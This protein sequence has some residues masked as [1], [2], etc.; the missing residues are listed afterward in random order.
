MSARSCPRGSSCPGQPG[1]SRRP[2]AWPRWSDGRSAAAR[3]D[4]AQGT[5]DLFGRQRARLHLDSAHGKPIAR[6]VDEDLA[7]R[8]RCCRLQIPGAPQTWNVQP[9]QI[10]GRRSTYRSGRR[11]ARRSAAGAIAPRQDARRAPRRRQRR[12]QRR[13]SRARLRRYRPPAD[14]RLSGCRCRNAATLAAA[15]WSNGV[16]E[17]GR[18]MK[19]ALDNA[20]ATAG[21][22]CETTT[23]LLKR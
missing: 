4:L 16:S 10:A 20:L 2:T 12:W 21:S 7:P 14:R 5:H 11:R 13:D 17:R 9:L 3:R 23:V 1:S 8:E 6:I 19:P 22:E 18:T 15:A